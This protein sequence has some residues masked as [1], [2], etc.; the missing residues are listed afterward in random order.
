M[1]IW[2]IYDH[3]R[4]KKNKTIVRGSDIN[5]GDYHLVIHICVLNNENKMLIQQRQP[6]KE[7]FSNL[8]DLTCGGSAHTGEDSRQAAHRELLEEIGLD[9]DFSSIRANLTINFKYG[10]DDYYVIRKNVELSKLKLQEEEVKAV[11]WASKAEIMDMI[12]TKEFIPYHKELIG[13]LFEIDKFDGA[14]KEYMEYG[15]KK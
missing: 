8:W 1:E 15:V 5:P 10:F 2:D 3:N 4:I 11:K 6:F 9:L 7:G 14:I 13:L 12:D